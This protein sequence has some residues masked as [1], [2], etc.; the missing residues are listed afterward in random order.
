MTTMCL[1]PS[2][3]SPPRC[4]AAGPAPR[5]TPS[6]TTAPITA[7]RRGKWIPEDTAT[8]EGVRP[9]G[10]PATVEHLSPLRYRRG[11][12]HVFGE[13]ASGPPAGRAWGRRTARPA[14]ACPD[15]ALDGP[16]ARRRLA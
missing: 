14:R 12:P 9:T 4:A 6:V 3:P 15:P 1:M 11:G 2:S 8:S 7:D 10:E 5:A 13:P 16:R